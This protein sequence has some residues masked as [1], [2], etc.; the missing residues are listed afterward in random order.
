MLNLLV[1]SSTLRASLFSVAPELRTFPSFLSSDSQPITTPNEPLPNLQQTA[2][3]SKNQQP[4]DSQPTSQQP[5]PTPPET[6][7][8]AVPPSRSHAKLV[9]EVSSLLTPKG[10]WAIR[11]ST[12]QMALGSS[13]SAFFA[14]SPAW[15]GS[16]SRFTICA[17]TFLTPASVCFLVRYARNLYPVRATHHPENPAAMTLEFLDFWGR[18]SP[19]MLTPEMVQPSKAPDQANSR[20]L[21]VKFSPQAPTDT[22]LKFSPDCIRDSYL[23]ERM[24]AGQSFDVKPDWPT[25]I[26]QRKTKTNSS[27]QPSSKSNK[28]FHLKK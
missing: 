4:P 3:Q 13:L 10:Q 22:L 20:D 11:L 2:T 14:L 12:L 19:R 21:F 5:T 17:L 24:M 18:L 25:V 15:E 9:Y 23:F 8:P 1:K 26:Q 6:P 27:D 16:T 7:A 28:K